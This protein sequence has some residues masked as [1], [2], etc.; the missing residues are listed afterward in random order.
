MSVFAVLGGAVGSGT[1][2][3]LRVMMA[4]CCS[5]VGSTLVVAGVLALLLSKGTLAITV[6]ADLPIHC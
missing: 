2:W 5:I 1:F 4:L 6:L 3:S